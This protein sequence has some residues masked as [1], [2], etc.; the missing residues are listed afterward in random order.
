MAKPKHKDLP[1]RFLPWQSKF[2][3]TLSRVT[4]HVSHAL[5]QRCDVERCWVKRWRLFVWLSIWKVAMGKPLAISAVGQS[6][7]SLFLAQHIS[8][9]SRDSTHFICNKR[10]ITKSNEQTPR[11]SLHLILTVQAPADWK[12]CELLLPGRAGSA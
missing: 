12:I 10:K 6:R 4:T 5:L 7:V 8:T 11:Q 9:K 3:R 2:L 1:I